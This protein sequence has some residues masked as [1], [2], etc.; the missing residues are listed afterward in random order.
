MEKLVLA[1]ACSIYDLSGIKNAFALLGFEVSFVDAPFMASVKIHEF[2][3][4]E[5]I[6][7]TAEL[8]PDALIVPLSEYWISYCK[9]TKCCRISKTALEASR[10]KEFLYKFMKDKDFDFPVIYEDQKAA[11]EA[12]EQGCR[13]I[14]KPVGLH[15]GYGIEILDKSG[16]ERLSKYFNEAGNIKNRTLRL[17]EIEN[18]G[19]ML[20]EAVEGTEYSADCF[21]YKGNVNVVRICRK[22]ITVINDKPCVFA[23]QLLSA[24]APEY[25]KYACFLKNWTEALF[26]TE[27]ISFAQYDFIASKDGRVVP[28][29]FASRVGGGITDLLMESGR[30]LYADAVAGIVSETEKS[31][32]QFSYLPVLSGYI[33]NDEYPLKKGKSRVFKKKGDYVISNPSSVGSRIALTVC[34]FDGEV[35]DSMVKDFLLGEDYISRTKLL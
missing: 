21:F 19:A 2:P 22:K 9:R 3:E 26:E 16:K 15:S 7:Y 24:E 20:T 1:G 6:V 12:L 4:T 34:R 35:T 30:N 14:I 33:K 5:E 32:V 18:S 25:Q 11:E 13:V 31:L 29:D 28:I 17:M 23:Y 10:S 8:P 27:D